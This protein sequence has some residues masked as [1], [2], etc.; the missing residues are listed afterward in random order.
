MKINLWKEVVVRSGSR[1]FQAYG[2]LSQESGRGAGMWWYIKDS[3]TLSRMWYFLREVVVRQD[4]G[5]ASRWW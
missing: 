4:G 5:N 1:L 3:G 2:T